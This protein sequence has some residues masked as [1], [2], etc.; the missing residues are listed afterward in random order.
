MSIVCESLRRRCPAG[1]SR[2]VGCMV[3]PPLGSETP[4]LQDGEADDKMAA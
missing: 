1:G 2:S 3:R 4:P